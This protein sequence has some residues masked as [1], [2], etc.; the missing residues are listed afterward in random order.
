MKF[1]SMKKYTNKRYEN[2]FNIDRYYSNLYGF[3]P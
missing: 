2:E 1:A 3:V